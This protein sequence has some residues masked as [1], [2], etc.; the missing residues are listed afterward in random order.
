MQDSGRTW[1]EAMPWVRQR[2]QETG[3]TDVTE[4]AMELDKFFLLTTQTP[5]PL[6]MISRGIDHLWHRL[7]E[8]TEFYSEFC[9]TRYG[10][11][12][13]HR[14]RTETMPVPDIAIRNFYNEYEKAFGQVPTIWER[15]ASPEMIAYGRG[16]A[17]FIPS[18]INWS[19]WPGLEVPLISCERGKSSITR[20]AKMKAHAFGEEQ[21][22]GS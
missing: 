17:D 21:P 18:E 7:I 16:R 15:D 5:K 3:G 13:H 8:Y 2:F 4:R 10:H 14:S 6:A 11:I 22:L 9:V 20:Y 12:V 1:L 19:G